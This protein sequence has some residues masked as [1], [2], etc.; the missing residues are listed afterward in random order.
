MMLNEINKDYYD[1][2][3]KAILDYVLKDDA[4]MLRIGIMEIYDGIVDYG[5]N[6]YKG[7][8]PDQ[9]WKDDVNAAKSE[10]T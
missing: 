4:E 2:V 1:S 3:R 8:E 6:Y 7:I 9:E 5:D 10:I